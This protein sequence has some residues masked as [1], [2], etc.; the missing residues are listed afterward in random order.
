MR[1]FIAIDLSPEIK[2]RLAEFVGRL[3]P[4]GRGV[5]W[6]TKDAMHLTLKFL[7][8]INETQV[9]E[10][11]SGLRPTAS[12]F[13]PIT[14]TCRGAGVFPPGSA[15]PRVL[16]V[17]VEAGPDL[18]L[19]QEDI[20]QCCEK[21]GFARE[22]RPFHPHLTL[23][24]VK[25]PADIRAVLEEFDRARTEVFGRM[26]VQRVTFFRSQLRPSGAEYSVLGE[27]PLQ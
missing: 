27:F 22:A 5:K 4:L 20:D 26:I 25:T 10:I 14:L 19:L 21:I 9:A 18:A 16:W 11:E 13:N 12:K 15:R 23:G 17:G 8:E 1:T 6:V 7:G 3:A 24:R 2:G